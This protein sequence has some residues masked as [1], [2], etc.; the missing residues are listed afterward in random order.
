MYQGTGDTAGVECR[1][2]QKSEVSVVAIALE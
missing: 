1:H 2:G